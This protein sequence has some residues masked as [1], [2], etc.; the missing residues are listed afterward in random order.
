M[1]PDAPS[2]FLRETRALKV[3]HHPHIVRFLWNAGESAPAL[4]VAQHAIG[5]LTLVLE[6]KQSTD[7]RLYLAKMQVVAGTA[8]RRRGTGRAPAAAIPVRQSH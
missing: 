8:A 7:L 4:Q 1:S 5:W 3:L 2:L 6:R